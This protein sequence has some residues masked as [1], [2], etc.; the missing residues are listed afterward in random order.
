MR[1]GTQ[2]RHGVKFCC[3]TVGITRGLC[4]LRA[5]PSYQASR[6]LDIFHTEAFFRRIHIDTLELQRP[7]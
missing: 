7:Y 2:G 3:H 1:S 6:I 4:S 5:V